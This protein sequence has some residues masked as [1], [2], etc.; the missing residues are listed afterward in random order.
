[1]YAVRNR[2]LAALK[3]LA[4]VERL[5]RCHAAA[6]AEIERRIANLRKD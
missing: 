2:G 3:E 4:T 6:M 1:M 5:S